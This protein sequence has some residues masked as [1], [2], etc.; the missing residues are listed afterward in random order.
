MSGELGWNESYFDQTFVS[1]C[2][3]FLSRSAPGVRWR[4]CGRWLR[5]RTP[6]R[7]NTPLPLPAGLRVTGFDSLRGPL[8]ERAEGDRMGA[9]GAVS[10][11][12]Q[13][14]AAGAFVKR[15]TIRRP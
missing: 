8:L 4:G 7:G 6:A 3:D 13:L 14:V 10:A 5:S 15:V 12:R 9:Q 1:P 2:C 11:V